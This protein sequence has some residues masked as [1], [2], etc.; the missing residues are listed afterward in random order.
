MDLN[1]LVVSKQSVRESGKAGT[2]W[3]TKLTTKNWSCQPL[4]FS[5]CCPI[6]YINIKRLVILASFSFGPKFTKDSTVGPLPEK[7][8]KF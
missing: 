6:L 1:S 4:P 3:G 7:C 2:M 8:M 5:Y